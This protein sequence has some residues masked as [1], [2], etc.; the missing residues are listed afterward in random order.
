MNIDE[1]ILELLKDKYQIDLRPILLTESINYYGEKIERAINFS[2]LLEKAQISLDELF[3]VDFKN[4][5]EYLNNLEK[6]RYFYK[7]VDEK[8]LSILK[9]MGLLLGFNINVYRALQDESE[10]FNN[11]I[12]FYK[13]YPTS[14]F[15]KS[16]QF[17]SKDAS[18]LNIVNN[19]IESNFFVKIFDQKNNC[20]S[21]I[22]VEINKQI[23]CK[24]CLEI[25]AY[26]I[27]DLVENARSKIK[28]TIEIDESDELPF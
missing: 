5:N 23:I 25:L 19:A 20:T 27:V 17:C 21:L 4:R 16:C 9:P 11:I 6:Q 18:V 12:D 7:L 13:F 28:I 3:K 26:P 24:D 22:G 2:S 8:F 10:S 14:V 1:T 15:D